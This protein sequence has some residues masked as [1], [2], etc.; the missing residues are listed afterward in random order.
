MPYDGQADIDPNTPTDNTSGG[1]QAPNNGNPLQTWAR[2]ALSDAYRMYLGRD[3][4]EAEFAQYTGP[5]ATQQSINQAIDFVRTSPESQHYQQA[6]PGAWGHLPSNTTT[7]T[8]TD[9]GGGGGGGGGGGDTNQ[10]NDFKGTRTTTTNINQGGP[11]GLEYIPP[12]PKFDAPGFQAPNASDVLKDPGYQFRLGQ[13]QQSLE[14]SAAARGLLNTGGTLKDLIGYGQNFA[15]QEYGNV[16]DRSE[17]AYNLAYRGAQDEFSPLMHQYDT[18]S[19][20][21][22]HQNDL[23]YQHS[24]DKWIQDYN[25][26]RNNNNDRFDRLYRTSTA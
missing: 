14:Q 25:I 5:S 16:Y 18:L 21:G 23:N 19:A 9:T 12:V 2:Q 20:A 6:N 7:N 22:Q 10:F 13:G 24:W 3:I 26:F 17:R 1:T 15:S 4:S 8:T 11:S